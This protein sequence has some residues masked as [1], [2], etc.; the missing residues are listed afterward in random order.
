[1]SSTRPNIGSL[2]IFGLAFALGSYFTFAAVQGDYLVFG[3]VEGWLHWV[4]ASD[5]VVVGRIRHERAPIR[6]TPQVSA[7]GLLFAIGS[8]GRLSAYRLP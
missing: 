4:R 2:M 1:M 8:E 3:D 6:G 5:G 7:N